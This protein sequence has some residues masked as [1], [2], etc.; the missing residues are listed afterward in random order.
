MN[1]T[2]P[3]FIDLENKPALV[4]GSGP[5]ADQREGVLR[6]SGARVT[7]LETAPESLG[8]YFMVISTLTDKE[9]NARLFQEAERLSILF[10]AHDDP[11]NCRF[12]FPSIHREGDL[13]VA[14]STNGKCPALA[15]R[16]RERVQE[17]FGVGYGEF[18]KIA[19]EMR[20]HIAAQIGEFS[21]KSALWYRM[22]DS[23]A[24]PLLQQ[25]KRKE[26]RGVLE[27]ILAEERVDYPIAAFA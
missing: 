14:V 4:I 11:A 17:Q 20:P 13:T 23:Q 22:V 16:I 10:S 12:V 24:I 2:F 3:V 25:G 27:G 18:L 9:A 26:A 8:G 7:V 5:M 21:Q 1:F 15:V 19:A 6:A